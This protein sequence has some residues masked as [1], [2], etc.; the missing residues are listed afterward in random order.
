M[1]KRK[2]TVSR[3]RPTPNAK[4]TAE[5]VGKFE[6]VKYQI[7]QLHTD[8]TTLAKKPDNAVNK[9]KLKFVNEKLM[10][11]NS[12]LPVAFRPSENFE[13]FDED[14]MPTTSDVL[15][16]LSQYIDSLEAWRSANV[17]EL[18]DG[19]FLTK[20]YWVTSDDSSIEATRP[21]RY[22]SNQE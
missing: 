6:R 7:H 21:S 11:A 19:S 17:Y 22:R 1:A 2:N 3:V 16:I 8:F 20:W 15:M 13:Q 10:E 5:E 14:N 4:L 12:L 18:T 9:F